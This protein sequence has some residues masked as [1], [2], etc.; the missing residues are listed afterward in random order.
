MSMAEI[1]AAVSSLPEN[2][3]GSLAARLLDS[4]PAHRGEDGTVDSLA[5]AA[6]R[7]DELDSGAVRPLTADELWA[8][9]GRE[10]ATW[11]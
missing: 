6:R 1:Q 2:E 9:I 8:S 11:R 3:R 10:R 7:R 4:L 5:E